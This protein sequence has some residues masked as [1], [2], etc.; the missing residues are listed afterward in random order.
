M[1]FAG[2]ILFVACDSGAV[3][4]F[5]TT[6]PNC[7]ISPGLMQLDASLTAGQTDAILL[8][9]VIQCVAVVAHVTGA[10]QAWFAARPI[11]YNVRT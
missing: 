3:L 4:L 5:T 6:F 10:R 2:A 8:A 11:D 7:L 9:L 1:C